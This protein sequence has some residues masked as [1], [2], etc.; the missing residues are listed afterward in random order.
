MASGTPIVASR[1]GAICE[2][3]NESNA[4]LFEPESLESFEETLSYALEH[5]EEASQKAARAYD[6]IH[7]FTWEKRVR[8]VLEY[9][10]VSQ[11]SRS[12]R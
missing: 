7:E 4:F 2:M 11:E 10:K 12:S 3:L 8:R 5:A 6:D 9:I 1:L